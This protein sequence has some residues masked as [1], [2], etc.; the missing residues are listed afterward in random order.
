MKKFIVILFILVTSNNYS[1]ANIIETIENEKKQCLNTNYL[2]DY[3][4]SQCNYKAIEKYDKEID[5]I[6]K[7]LEKNIGRKQYS[8]LV[9]SQNKWD[10]FIQDDNFLLKNLYEK[11]NSLEKELIISSIQCQNKK[12]RLEELLILYHS[13]NNK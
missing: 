2:N 6:I 7:K 1:N 4:M 8:L 12:Y 5:E 3:F 11:D 9:Q 10:K 13:I